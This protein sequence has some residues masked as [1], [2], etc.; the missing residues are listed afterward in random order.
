MNDFLAENISSAF[1]F[2]KGLLPCL[3]SILV[4]SPALYSKGLFIWEASQ[5]GNRDS[6]RGSPASEI[7]LDSYLLLGYFFS[8]IWTSGLAR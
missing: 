4:S 1:D 5:P 6:D 2:E 3:L 8:F 7:S